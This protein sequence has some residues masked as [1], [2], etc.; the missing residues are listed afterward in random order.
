M[1]LLDQQIE[2]WDFK[3]VDTKYATHGI[4]YY[5][6]RMIPQI[7]NRLISRYTQ[8]YDL[9]LDPFCGSGTV[10]LECKLL[11]RNAIG[12]DINPLAC[13][14]S[15]VKI[16]SLNGFDNKSL[17]I[18]FDKF[19]HKPPIDKMNKYI[20]KFK[21]LK[22]W[23]TEKTIR[24]LLIIKYHLF[25][26]TFSKSIYNFL[27]ICF[28]KTVQ[29]VSKGV[30]DGSSTHL[31]KNLQNF[32]PQ[33]F[34]TFKKN[35]IITLEKLKNFNEKY[36]STETLALL[37]DSRNI[38]IKNNSVDCIITSPPYGEEDNTIGYMRWTKFSLFWLDFTPDEL[39]K[40]KKKS[41][42]STKIKKTFIGS[43]VLTNY[44]KD[45]ELNDRKINYINS[46]FSDY[47]L[48]LKEMYRTLKGGKFCCIVIGN[49]RIAKK[50]LFMDKIT[51]ELATNIGYEH[52]NTFYRQIPTKSI[53]WLGISGKT[54]KKENIIILKK[55]KKE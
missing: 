24:D 18:L 52:I 27:R 47:Y 1:N 22:Y 19:N 51:S 39:L 35:V 34:E 14:L 23:F 6:A 25:N 54:I 43:K 33:V 37:G 2:D 46:F 21:N 48:C 32:F 7:A 15:N 28:S 26:G 45:L 36:N 16:S 30:F 49:R 41:L 13:L 11:N 55:P 38:S 29:E 9:I 5:P 31:K 20:P 44:I 53:P 50:P 10:L 8:P 40:L 12:F 4:H 17:K 3:G 42:G